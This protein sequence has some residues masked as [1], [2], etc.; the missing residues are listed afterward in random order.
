MLSKIKQYLSS[1]DIEM[2]QLGAILL[3]ENI[4]SHK[5]SAILRETCK[6]YFTIEEDQIK[7]Y[8]RGEGV[9]VNLQDLNTYK[10]IY[11]MDTFSLYTLTE[12]IEEYHAK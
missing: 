2:V 9:W 6:F 12:A 1:D 7:I 5:W 4:P 10:H 8:K 11:D 3:K